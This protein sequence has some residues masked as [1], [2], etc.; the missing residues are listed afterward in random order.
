MKKVI[1]ALFLTMLAGLVSAQQVSIGRND[2]GSG[3]PGA[4]GVE[5]ATKW[6]NDI[7]HASQYMPGYP[8]AAPLWVRVINVTCAKAV[9]GVNCD[10]YNWLPEM[11]RGEYLMIRPV[12]VEAPKPIIKEVPVIVLK[13]VPVKKKSE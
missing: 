11:G 9:N 12:I 8:T 7:Y 13:E 5:N 2:A 10:G 1:V 6:D 4:F 3:T